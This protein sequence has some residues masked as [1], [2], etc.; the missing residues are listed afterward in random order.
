MMVSPHPEAL[1]HRLK[2]S[3]PPDARLF[4]IAGGHG[5]RQ[6][7]PEELL[8]FKASGAQKKFGCKGLVIA[9]DVAIS[10][11]AEAGVAAPVLAAM[12]GIAKLQPCTPHLPQ[13]QALMPPPSGVACIPSSPLSREVR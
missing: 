7:E 3:K 6:A 4:W 13:V 11:C 9:V 5:C 8:F 12:A 2:D 10:A 1:F